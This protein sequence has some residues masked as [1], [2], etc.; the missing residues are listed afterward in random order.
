MKA[1]LLFVNHQILAPIGY[2]SLHSACNKI[3]V[4]YFSAVRGKR[5]WVREDKVLEIVEIDVQKIK[6]RG[7]KR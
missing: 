6:G 1:Y 4:S 7:K 2:T 5:K 3:E